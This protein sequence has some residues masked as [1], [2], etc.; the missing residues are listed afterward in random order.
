MWRWERLIC[1][2]GNDILE[3]LA[4]NFYSE[5]EA[6]LF[7]LAM[8]DLLPAELNFSEKISD[9]G[10]CVFELIN[11]K[12]LLSFS[13]AIFMD[14]FVY[15]ILL[16]IIKYYV[17]SFT[18]NVSSI[19]TTRQNVA[20]RLCLTLVIFP[21]FIHF[22][23]NSSVSSSLWTLKWRSEDAFFTALASIWSIIFTNSNEKKTC[24]LFCLLCIFKFQTLACQSFWIFYFTSRLTLYECVVNVCIQR[25]FLIRNWTIDGS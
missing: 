5:V 23:A 22:F 13:T 19:S 14:L 18:F 21:L 16:S 1:V 10:L 20:A 6:K 8:N 9:A 25:S 4:P 3:N 2:K 7:L 15:S 12:R 17:I 24:L 11:I